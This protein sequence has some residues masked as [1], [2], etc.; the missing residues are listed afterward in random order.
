[1]PCEGGHVIDHV[2]I[3]N[4]GVNAPV[5]S[6]FPKHPLPTPTL[7]PLLPVVDDMSFHRLS[8]SGDKDIAV[9]FGS[10]L[11]SRQ[12][13]SINHLFNNFLFFFQFKCLCAVKKDWK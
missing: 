4:K 5:Q 9:K 8:S 1:M 2:L 11:A 10:D 13:P 6:A 3:D 12:G 7:L